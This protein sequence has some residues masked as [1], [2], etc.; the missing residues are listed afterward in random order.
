MVLVASSRP[1]SPSYSLGTQQTSTGHR[2]GRGWE[3]ESFAEDVQQPCWGWIRKELKAGWVSTL[4]L[5]GSR[6]VCDISSKSDCLTFIRKSPEGL[7]TWAN[8]TC[9]KIDGFSRQLLPDA[10]CYLNPSSTKDLE[11]VL[12]IS[13]VWPLNRHWRLF[14]VPWS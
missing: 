5:K 6:K 2:Q 12:T 3:W 13:Q 14:A 8:C 4:I 9:H 1:Q 7:Q 11:A 10:I